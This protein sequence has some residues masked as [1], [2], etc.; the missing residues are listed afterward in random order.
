MVEEYV[1][2]DATYNYIFHRRK[3]DCIDNIK[4]APQSCFDVHFL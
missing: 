1:M 4:N 2:K 3:T